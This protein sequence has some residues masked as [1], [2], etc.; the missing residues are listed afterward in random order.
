ML[1]EIVQSRKAG[2]ALFIEQLWQ[3]YFFELKLQEWIDYNIEY[4][5]GK[6]DENWSSVWST[7]CRTIWHWRNQR[8]HVA[9]FVV[10]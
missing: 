10:P 8:M 1:C 7:V 5:L 4:L 2:L 9:D 3:T 6:D